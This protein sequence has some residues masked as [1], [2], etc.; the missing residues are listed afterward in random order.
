MIESVKERTARDF[1]NWPDIYRAFI[2]A[3]PPPPAEVA[4]GELL[5]RKFHEAYERL[6]QQFGYETRL[7][8]RIFDPDSPNGR[9][10]IA[11]CSELAPASRPAPVGVVD[12]GMAGWL[13]MSDEA[14]KIQARHLGKHEGD[15]YHAMQYLRVK[16]GAPDSRPLTAALIPAAP[17]AESGPSWEQQARIYGQAIRDAATKAGIANADVP[18]DGPLLLMLLDDM[19]TA[20]ASPPVAAGLTGE[21]GP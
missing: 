15:V 6:A 2:A 8:T 12:E 7:E 13:A 17:V 10:M 5:A 18:A 20:L 1:Y 16:F 21:A 14:S 3:A 19:A 11:V 9:L 4:G